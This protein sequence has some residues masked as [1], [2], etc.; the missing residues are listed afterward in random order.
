MPTGT[1]RSG[2]A[3]GSKVGKDQPTPSVSQATGEYTA[4]A[5]G[6]YLQRPNAQCLQGAQRQGCWL[7][8]SLNHLVPQG[9]GVLSCSLA[10]KHGPPACCLSSPVVSATASDESSSWV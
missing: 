2:I 3:P 4:T 9:N 7:S 6:D 5:T 1:Q 10:G 8:Q